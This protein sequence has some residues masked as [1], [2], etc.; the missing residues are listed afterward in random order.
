MKEKATL[1]IDNNTERLQKYL[2][3]ILTLS[4][5][6]MTILT[7]GGI[8]A[9]NNAFVHANLSKSQV[10]FIHFDFEIDDFIPQYDV[11]WYEN[12]NEIKYTVHA[13]TGEVM[14]TNQKA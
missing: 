12:S 14:K 8:F 5:I 1:F 6:L 13:F 7:I 3:N 11:S 4:V 2:Y 9:T 10:S